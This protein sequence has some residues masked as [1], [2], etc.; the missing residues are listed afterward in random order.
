MKP[1]PIPELPSGL[2]VLFVD[3]DPDELE[4]YRLM[5]E[6]AGAQTAV[7]LSLE[8]A[9]RALGVEPF[10]VVVSDVALPDGSGYELVRRLRGRGATP[11]VVAIALTGYTSPADRAEALAAGFDAHCPKPYLPD[12]LVALIARLAGAPRARGAAGG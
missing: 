11:R 12:D 6:L 5:F 8:E 4:M 3:D 7:A 10:D 1:E 9:T 2:R